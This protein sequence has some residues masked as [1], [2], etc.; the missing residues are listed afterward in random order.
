MN[1]GRTTPARR[2][3]AV[4]RI[5][6]GSPWWRLAFGG[7]SFVALLTFGVV[8]YVVIEG[9]SFIDALY[10]TVTT[11]TTVGFREVQPLGDGGRIFTI[12]LVL[13]GVGVALYILTAVVQTVVE[14]ELAQA[15]GVRRMKARIDALRDHFILCGFGRVGEEIGRELAQHGVPFVIVENNPEALERAQRQGYLYIDG[16]ATQDAVLEEAGVHRARALMAASDSDAGNTYITLTSKALRPALFVVARVGHVASEP[17]VRR[18][19]ADRVISP[20]SLAGRRM[21]LSALQ[22]LTVDFID[23]LA[24]ARPGEQLLAELVVSEE[25]VVA[26]MPVHEATHGCRATTILAVQHPDGELLVG[27]PGTYVL[28]AGD[29]LML[30]SNE[31]DMDDLGRT[32]P[33]GDGSSAGAT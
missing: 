6:T 11:V 27:P 8:G 2:E 28:R 18:A 33:S 13:F 23:V 16:D 4:R 20:Y 30:L 22:P 14:G 9:W 32:R 29:R 24:S 25:S 15:L 31:S 26:G 19:G 1:I 3:A 5:E 7:A 10:M 12:F 21:A 17:R